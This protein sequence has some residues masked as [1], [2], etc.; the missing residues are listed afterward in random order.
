MDETLD[1]IAE[2]ANQCEEASRLFSAEPVASQMDKLSDAIA[3]VRP[4]WSGSWLGYHADLYLPGFREPRQGERFDPNWGHNGPFSGSSDAWITHPYE[5][6]KAEILQR[7]GVPSTAAIEQANKQARETFGQ[8]REELLPLIDA[9]LHGENDR[10]LVALRKDIAE[11]PADMAWQTLVQRWM[12]KNFLTQDMLAMSQAQQGREA[13]P[14]LRFE[15]WLLSMRSGGIQTAELAKLT[16]RVQRYLQQRAKLKGGSMAKTTGTVFIGHG[17]DPVWRELKDFLQDRLLLKPDEFNRESPAGIETTVRLREML[18]KASFA[19]LIMTAENEDAAGQ[20]HARENV[21]HE[22][23]LFQGHLGF[24]KAIVL[25]E[26]GCVEFSNIHGLG[27]I[28]F[29]KGNIAA[30]LEEIRQVLEREGIIS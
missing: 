4:S 14:H 24:R 8:A 15:A 25:L 7:A 1:L 9:L 23:G 21:I 10:S 3:S 29:D 16:R 11:L 12:P 27:Q 5:Q 30:K 20:L 6:V 2:V 28:R 18:D 19:F 22:V 13:P 26:N 17:R